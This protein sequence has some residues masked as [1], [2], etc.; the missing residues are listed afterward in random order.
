MI[1]I[2]KL[3]H[4]EL[5]PAVAQAKEARYVLVKLSPASSAGAARLPRIFQA[6]SASIGFLTRFSS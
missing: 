3:G 1:C 5:A 4:F 2:P 6:G